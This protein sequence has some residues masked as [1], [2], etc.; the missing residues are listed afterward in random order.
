MAHSPGATVLVKKIMGMK[1]PKYSQPQWL[2]FKI[3]ALRVD[4][5]GTQLFSDNGSDKTKQNTTSKT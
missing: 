5:M 4:M 1:S 2:R 3:N